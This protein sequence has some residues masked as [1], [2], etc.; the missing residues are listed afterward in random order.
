MSLADD[1]DDV[2][3]QLAK[4]QRNKIFFIS[5]AAAAAAFGG[6][7][8]SAKIRPIQKQG[9]M[10]AGLAVRMILPSDIP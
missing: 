10:Y 3:R 2:A 9:V 4:T 1:E 6:G 5:V 7:S 8:T